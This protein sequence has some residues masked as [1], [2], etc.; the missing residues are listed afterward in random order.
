M[1]DA[2]ALPSDDNEGMYSDL[3]RIVCDVLFFV[4]I[5]NM[6]IGRCVT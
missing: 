5:V 3:S 4:V 2:D 1:S 6:E